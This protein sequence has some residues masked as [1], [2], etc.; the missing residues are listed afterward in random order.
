MIILATNDDGVYSPGLGTLAKAVEDLGDVYVVAPDREQS[1]VSHSVTLHRPMLVEEVKERVY[2][3]N[4]TPTDCVLLAATK[5][6]PEKPALVISGINKGGNLGEDILYSG[7]V[8]AAMEGALMGIPSVAFSMVA[9]EN[10]LFNTT[11]AFIRNL[12]G[13]ILD[14]GLPEGNYLNVNFPNVDPEEIK[15]VRTTVQGRRTYV[16]SVLERIDPRGKKYYWLGGETENWHEHERAD[17]TAVRD[18]YISVTPLKLDIT[19]HDLAADKD[20][21]DGLHV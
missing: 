5:L 16:G 4:G 20:T 14:E 17:H 9:R 11:V 10:F 6:L 8:S 13:K 19:A 18:G 2:A 12:C 21:Y 7:T 3:V 1:A 15:G